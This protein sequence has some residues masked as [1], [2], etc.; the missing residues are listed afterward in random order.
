MINSNP[1]LLQLLGSTQ[2]ALSVPQAKAKTFL[3]LFFGLLAI[4]FGAIATFAPLEG[5]MFGSNRRSV[6]SW[7]TALWAGA[8]SAGLLCVCFLLMR[9]PDSR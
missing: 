7:E 8:A 1:V 6:V 9:V 5:A 3:I 4:V 2:T